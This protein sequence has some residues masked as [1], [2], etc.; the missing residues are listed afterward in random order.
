MAEKRMH[1]APGKSPTPLCGTLAKN[2]CLTIYG[3]H[4]VALFPLGKRPTFWCKGCLV[5]YYSK[6]KGG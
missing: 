2:P 1:I 4:Q 5:A 3:P 6:K